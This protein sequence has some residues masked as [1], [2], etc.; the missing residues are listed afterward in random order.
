VA[1]YT[2]Q[3]FADYLES[4][5]ND[6]RATLLRDLVTGLI[7]EVA[8]ATWVL[9]DASTTVKAIA[10]AAAGRA[11]VNPQGLESQ[12]RA[13]DDYSTTDR[14][15]ADSVGLFLTDSEVNAITGLY[16]TSAGAF[17]IRPYYEPPTSSLESWA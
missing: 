6:A 15:S 8:G 9:D 17:T 12:T 7:A 13:I 11:Y 4:D 2:I 5:V 16:G 10:L 14:W 1:L 3:E